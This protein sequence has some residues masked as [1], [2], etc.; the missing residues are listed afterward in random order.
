[1]AV[2][3][4][5]PI[6]FSCGHAEEKDL[7]SK[8]ADERAG[9]AGWLSQK[10]CTAC[11]REDQDLTGDG[12]STQEWI[13]K[14]RAEEAETISEWEAVAHMP[15]LAG[16][17]KAI[18]WARRSRHAVLTVAYDALVVTGG[19]AEDDWAAM[20][21]EPARRIDRAS[22]WIDNRAAEP[23]EIAELVEAA[24]H[25]DAVSTENEFA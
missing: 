13:A 17:A 11:W 19:L 18:D 21:E 9:Y 8:R 2:K 23:A 15:T 14:R 7:S 22:W 10:K 4:V 3:T 16:A 6:T 12:L 25:G 20:I 1:M 24:R 5:W